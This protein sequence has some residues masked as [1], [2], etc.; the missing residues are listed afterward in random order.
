LAS[1]PGLT[2]YIEGAQP[3]EGS[4]ALVTKKAAVRAKASNKPPTG[5]TA[6]VIPIR[7]CSLATTA[8][9]GQLISNLRVDPESPL[10]SYNLDLTKDSYQFAQVPYQNAVYSLPSPSPSVSSSSS[11]NSPQPV[12]GGVKRPLPA[13]FDLNISMAV[14]AVL[15]GANGQFEKIIGIYFKSAH[16]WLTIVRKQRFI[17]RVSASRLRADASVAI[18]LL[19]MRLVAEPFDRAKTK[20]DASRDT[21]YL[22]AKNLHGIIQTSGG[23][24]LELIQAGLLI[25]LFEHNSAIPNVAYQTLVNCAK[26]SSFLGLDIARHNLSPGQNVTAMEE[27]KKRTYWGIVSLERVIM[28][29]DEKHE[30]QIIMPE[31]YLDDSLPAVRDVFWENSDDDTIVPGSNYTVSGFVPKDADSFCRQVQASRLMGIVQEVI[32]IPYENNPAEMRERVFEVDKLLQESLGKLLFDCDGGC[33]Q[34][35]GPISLCVA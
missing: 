12:Q 21:I 26:M 3:G 31:P 11:R 34:Y 18:L 10:N 30:R 9:P 32:R 24:S 29:H 15:D 5:N 14:Y 35:C 28:L 22:A 16:S 13:D 33:T 7:Q 4:F 2:I 19:C 6:T 1:K 8:S 27:E 23:P 17:K 25:A 20:N